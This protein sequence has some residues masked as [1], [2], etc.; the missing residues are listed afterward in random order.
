MES[1]SSSSS[2]H[3]RTDQLDCFLSSFLSKEAISFLTVYECQFTYIDWIFSLN[4]ND[5]DVLIELFKQILE[6]LI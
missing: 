6:V 3:F 1:Y 2:N 5:H 4:R